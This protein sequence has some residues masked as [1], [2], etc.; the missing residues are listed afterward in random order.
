MLIEEL[1]YNENGNGNGKG[2]GK[3]EGVMGRAGLWDNHENL[4]VSYLTKLSFLKGML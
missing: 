4:I 2:K 1:L 3:E